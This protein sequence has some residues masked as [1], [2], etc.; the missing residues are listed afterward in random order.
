V[1]D[2]NGCQATDT[3]TVTINPISVIDAGKS[4]AICTGDSIKLGGKPTATNSFFG[5]T[6]KWI[7]NNYSNSN[8]VTFPTSTTTYT[9]IVSS[10]DCKPDTAYVTVIVNS[11]PITTV[12]ADTVT[13]G[14]GDQINVSANGV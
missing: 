3:I 10:Y 6:Y 2:A 13:I 8:S 12:S 4:E 5:Y 1:V 14:N 11:L 7:P 9:L